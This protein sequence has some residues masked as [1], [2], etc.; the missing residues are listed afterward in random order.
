MLYSSGSLPGMA[1]HEQ[2]INADTIMPVLT[3][4]PRGDRLLHPNSLS[5]RGHAPMPIEVH[6][7]N[8]GWTHGRRDGGGKEGRCCLTQGAQRPSG[9]A[10]QR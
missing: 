9:D 5:R 1:Q 7:S 2:Y 3:R 6:G 8:E 10:L 4:E